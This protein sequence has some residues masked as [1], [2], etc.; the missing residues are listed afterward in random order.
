MAKL[1]KR[2]KAL[3]A[4]VEANKLYTAVEAL[5]LIKETAVAKFDESVD[6]AVQLGIDPRKS[7]Q[8]VRRGCRDAGRHGQDRSRCRVHPGRQG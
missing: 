3:N 2:M 1:C 8:A 7:D 5:E 4:K 6:V